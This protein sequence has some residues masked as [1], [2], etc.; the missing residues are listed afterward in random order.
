MLFSVY[1]GIASFIVAL[2]GTRLT[3]L[4]LRK[5]NAL[6]DRPNPRSN[7]KIPTPRGGGVA[8]VATLVIFLML[9]DAPISL[10]LAL[11]MLASVSL[12][13]DII[14]L[15]PLARL[16]VQIAAVLVALPSLGGT[17]FFGG[18]LP[19]WAEGTIVVL[20]WL[21]FINLFN[22]MDGIDGLA[23]C[24]MISIGFGLLIICV[25]MNYFP[26]ELPTYALIV[27]ATGAGFIW[28]NWYPAKIFMGD[29]GSVPVGFLLGYLLI[30]ACAKGFGFA[31][32]ILPAYYLAD[33][34]ITLLKRTRQGKKIWQAHSEHYYQQAVRSGKSHDVVVRHVFGINM[35]LVLLAVYAQLTPEIAWLNL[36]TAYVIVTALLIA[37]ARMYH[38]HVEK[39]R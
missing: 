13:D 23:A 12:L 17:H 15:S 33:S 21:W 10:V 24:E 16:S 19:P 18:F 32:F 8:I 25:I 29:V 34:S 20:G 3:I 35:L 28:W 31:A 39:R 14:S 11:L 36:V 30:L 7:H 37:Y 22:F 38:R 9:S 6:L 26:Q 27:G 5:R 4:A 1:I 2:V